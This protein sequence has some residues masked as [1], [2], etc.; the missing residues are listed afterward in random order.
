MKSLTALGRFPALLALGIQG[1]AF[2]SVWLFW[3]IGQRLELNLAL[4]LATGTAAIVQGLLAALLSRQLKLAPWWWFIQLFFPSALFIALGLHLPTILYLSCFLL[5]L[6]IYGHNFRTQ[7]PY[8]PSNR[9]TWQSLQTYLPADRPFKM[10]DAGSGMGGMILDLAR[11]YRD[12]EFV[13]IELAPLV[14]GISW[15]RARMQC[16]RA[17]FL[18]ADYMNTD[19]SRYDVVFAY[20]S[21]AAMP[22][23]W[24]KARREMRPGTILFS[25]EFRIAE[26]AADIVVHETG[27]RVP[28][29]LWYM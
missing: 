11:R 16:S 4:S 3:Q 23:L 7:V 21:P 5:L 19:L 15:A 2:L 26:Q 25:N 22:A 6:P 18:H 10:L 27:M 24:E 20:L 14:W 13:G 17:Q 28:L 9:A 8:F 1:A 12:S 29:F